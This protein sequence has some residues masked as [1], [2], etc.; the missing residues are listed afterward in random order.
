[1]KGFFI[2]D[3]PY[4]HDY[5]CLEDYHISIESQVKKEFMMKQF[6]TDKIH[7]INDYFSARKQAKIA[8]VNERKNRISQVYDYLTQNNYTLEWIP[9][10]D[11]QRISFNCKDIVEE[12]TLKT[13]IHRDISKLLGVILVGEFEGKYVS[14]IPYDNPELM[15]QAMVIPFVQQSIMYSC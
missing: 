6:S 15:K 3:R 2:L 11:S 9:N 5:G 10:E 12:H 7:S 4:G 14:P 1:M 13:Q 8:S